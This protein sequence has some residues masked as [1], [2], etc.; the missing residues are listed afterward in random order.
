MTGIIFFFL[1]FSRHYLLRH[2]SS[3]D[4]NSC[5]FMTAVHKYT[6]WW[7][8]TSRTAQ[9]CDTHW[10]A[11]SSPK[12][13]SR[14]HLNSSIECRH[15]ACGHQS[16]SINKNSVTQSIPSSLNLSFIHLYIHTT[17]DLCVFTVDAMVTRQLALVWTL[18]L[19]TGIFVNSVCVNSICVNSVWTV[20]VPTYH[21]VFDFIFI[22]R[23]ANVSWW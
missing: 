15:A 8:V 22:C 2:L 18:Y 16:K 3:I 10:P 14:L 23:Q 1:S 11:P 20:C 5:W 4:S 21:V 9:P 13:Q 6:C 7:Q 12:L 17:T 19:W